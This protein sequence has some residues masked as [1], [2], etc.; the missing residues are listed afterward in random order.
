MQA[1][2]RMAEALLRFIIFPSGAPPTTLEYIEQL[3]NTTTD[4]VLFFLTYVLDTCLKIVR[5][6]CLKRAQPM[7]ENMLKHILVC[8][9]LFSNTVPNAPCQSSVCFRPVCIAAPDLL[10][11][12]HGHFSKRGPMTN[13]IGIPAFVFLATKK[14]LRHRE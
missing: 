12:V 1:S 5:N 6:I 8:V 13:S 11:F 4:A 14:R 10:W 7:F 2:P 3:L 9:F